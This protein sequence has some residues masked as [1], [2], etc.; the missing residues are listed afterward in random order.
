MKR[1]LF[2]VLAVSMFAFASCSDD[3]PIVGPEPGSEL[4]ELSGNIDKDATVKAGEVTLKNATIVRAGATL[5]IPAG[6]TITATDQ[7]AYLLV[8]RGAK[9][10][11][12]GT[13]DKP[14]VFTASNKKSGAWGG[15]IINGKAPISRASESAKSEFQT[16]INANILYGGDD[17][18]DNSGILD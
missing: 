11:A 1:K 5:T 3:D 15:L 8:E 10:I 17:V 2:A 13:A 4:V 18:A 7:T 9:I 12:Q 16:E 14:I 6:T